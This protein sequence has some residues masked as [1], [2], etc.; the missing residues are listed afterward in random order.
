[1]EQTM[2]TTIQQ[3][4]IKVV[5]KMLLDAIKNFMVDLTSTMEEEFDKN[6]EMYNTIVNRID[7]TKVNSYQRLVS[8]FKIFFE[9][10]Q[11]SLKE[12]HFEDLSNPNIAYSSENGT[13]SFNF[14][15]ILSKLNDSEQE[16]VKDHLNHI[17]NLLSGENKS[18]EE[19]YIDRIF[20]N[21]K[22]KCSPDLTKDEQMTI[23]KDLFSDFQTQNL[24]IG[25]VVKAACQKSRQL[26]LQNGSDTNTATLALI[27]SVEEIDINNFNMVQFLALVGKVGTL[28]NDTEN[29]P[30]QSILSNVFQTTEWPPIENIKLNQQEH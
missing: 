8:G 27:S 6:F 30:L 9:D 2:V 11:E 12:G 7:E 23:A 16:T 22:S 3:N 20:Q 17:W 18:E 5:D 25:K 14:E 4:D 21:L 24:D 13:F 15:Q 28:F 26:L 29:N 1:M 10:N 19:R